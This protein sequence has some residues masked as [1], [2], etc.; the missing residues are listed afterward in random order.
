MTMLRQ[1]ALS[2]LEIGYRQGRSRYGGDHH[3]AGAKLL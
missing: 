1:G 2:L 3:P